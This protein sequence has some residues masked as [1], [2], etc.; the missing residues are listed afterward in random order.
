MHFYRI[1]NSTKETY[2]IVAK[3]I[4]PSFESWILNMC[5]EA[6]IDLEV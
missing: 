4:K 5:K 1:Y 2:A 6:I 3:F